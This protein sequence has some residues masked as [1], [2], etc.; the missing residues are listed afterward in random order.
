MSFD[1][2]G[3]GVVGFTE[4]II[5]SRFDKDKDMKLNAEERDNAIQAIKNGVLDQYRFGIDHSR[6]GKDHRI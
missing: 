2:D 3:D 6:E 1:L 5:G 4:Y